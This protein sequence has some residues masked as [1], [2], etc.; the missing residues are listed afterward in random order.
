M[1]S[2]VMNLKYFW[3]GELVLSWQSGPSMSNQGSF[4]NFVIANLKNGF[5]VTRMLWMWISFQNPTTRAGTYRYIQLSNH[6]SLNIYKYW[7]SRQEVNSQGSNSSLAGRMLANYPAGVKLQVWHLGT[8]PGSVMWGEYQLWTRLM[9]IAF[10]ILD[11]IVYF[12][13]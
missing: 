10:L 13:Q 5:E 4:V 3:F 1:M 8:S 7:C 6:L 11:F 12:Y 2:H 9:R